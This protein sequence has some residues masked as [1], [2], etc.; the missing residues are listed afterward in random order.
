LLNKFPIKTLIL[1]LVFDD[2]R[3][4]KIRQG[5]KETLEDKDTIIRIKKTF[6]G[7]KLIS[8]YKDKDIAGN[9]LI[10]KETIQD[11]FEKKINIKFEKIW[12]VWENRHGLRSELINKL[13]QLRNLI[14]G[15]TST[16]PRKIIRGPYTDNI[17]AFKDIL[18]LANKKNINILT[19]ISPIRN[20]FKI[21][22]DLNEYN[23][24][25]K[26]IKVI[27]Q[28]FNINLYNFENIVPAQFWGQRKSINHHDIENIDFMHFK[29]EGH[30]LLADAL[31]LEVN[32]P[33]N[34]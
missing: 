17:N 15:I 32:K 11:N 22:Y 24:F 3:E 25:K 10:K 13:Y 18:R 28:K 8:R 34:K 30:R 19:Y 29:S 16:T 26:E 5:I 9:E 12:S 14:F 7:K 33:P 2:M 20:D 21:P 6:T 31:F 1:P 4:D 27:S 23:D